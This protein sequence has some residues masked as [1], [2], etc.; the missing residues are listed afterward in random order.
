MK[1]TN[2]L[3]LSLL[4]ILFLAGC[5][6]PSVHPLYT[7]DDLIIQEALTG[8]WQ[9]KVG[10]ASYRVFNISELSTNE[11]LRDS[12]DIEE[13][14][15]FIADFKE[16]G[17]QRLY[18][19]VDSDFESQSEPAIYL[20]GLLKINNNYFLDLYKYPA[21]GDVFSFPVHIFTKV[22]LHENELV[23]YEFRQDWIKD[24]IE[25]RQLRIKHE[26]S[27]D[28]FL[29]TASTEELQK[30]VSKYGDDPEAYSGNK[31]IYVKT[32]AP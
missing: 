31:Q 4:L 20:G 14:D 24:L 13:D 16:K 10:G 2:L 17:L 19:I 32:L 23:M 9:K 11:A 7:P 8:Q 29:L 27:F 5:G 30:F 28:N 6:I 12:L 15:K 22:E 1:N 18:L 3:I 25:K 21:L 26:V